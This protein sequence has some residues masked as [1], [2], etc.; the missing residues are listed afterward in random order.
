MFL[1]FFFEKQAYLEQFK[2]ELEGG[3]VKRQREPEF[4]KMWLDFDKQ[5]QWLQHVIQEL[6]ESKEDLQKTRQGSFLII[7]S[8]SNE[9][10]PSIFATL[11]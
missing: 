6:V 3:A 4:Y 9:E 2:E 1:Q 11:V 8:Q 10:M 7:H 5:I